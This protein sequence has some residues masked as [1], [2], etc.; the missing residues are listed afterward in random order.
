MTPLAIHQFWQTVDS[1]DWT[2]L[3]RQDDAELVPLLLD[4]CRRQPNL[5]ELPADDLNSYILS[6]LPLIREIAS[7]A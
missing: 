1:L 6:R 2:G 3:P 7:S 4:V 5:D